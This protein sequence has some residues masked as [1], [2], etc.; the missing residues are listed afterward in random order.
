MDY[1]SDN[2][3]FDEESVEEIYHMNSQE[4]ELEASATVSN[5]IIDNQ[6][7]NNSG[8]RESTAPTILAVNDVEEFLFKILKNEIQTVNYR[9]LAKIRQLFGARFQ[10]ES[11][12][13][14][15][16]GTVFLP[17][18]VG[19]IHKRLNKFRSLDSM[20][21]FGDIIG[22]IADECCMSFYKTSPASYFHTSTLP[23]FYH[24]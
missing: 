17:C 15:H 9:L 19:L 2:E 11:V 22:F 21:G 20:I 13:P 18:I 12:G 1:Y 6:E 23:A 16:I 4:D 10:A 24:P 3:F 14:S 7:P 8:W 5:L